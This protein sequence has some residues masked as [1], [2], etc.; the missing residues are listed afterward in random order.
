MCQPA[1]HFLGC[2]SLRTG[3]KVVLVVDALYGLTLVVMHSML[4]NQVKEPRSELLREKDLSIAGARRLQV[5]PGAELTAMPAGEQGAGVAAIAQAAAERA[6][7]QKTAWWLQFLDLDF[8]FGHQ[9]FSLSDGANLVTGL[10]YGVIVIGVSLYVLQAIQTH[11]PSLGSTARWFTTFA[12]LQILLYTFVQLVKWPKLCN[13]IQREYLTHLY[14]ECH[15]L[16]HVYICRSIF[17][18]VVFSL[19]TWVFGSFSFVLTFGHAAHTAVD[20]PE[21]GEALDLPPVDERKGPPDDVYASGRPRTLPPRGAGSYGVQV[22]PRPS[23]AEGYY[24]GGAGNAGR[25]ARATSS[26]ATSAS[27]YSQERNPL[28]RPPIAIY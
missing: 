9:L 21:Y 6:G 15:V 20:R 25:M 7:E 28:I 2:F 5:A 26:M 8:G 3:A 18:I 4:L 19:G 17:Y 23:A 22:A 16:W 24:L 11:S 13:V 14:M 1:T 27:G 10:I 12:H